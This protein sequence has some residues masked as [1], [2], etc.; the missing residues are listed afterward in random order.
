MKKNSHKKNIE[1]T[2]LECRL[3]FRVSVKEKQEI[4]HKA[5]LCAMSP[6][7]Y[8]RRCV[9]G[10]TPKL[11]LTEQETK[12]FISLA[13]ARAD[14]VHIKNALSGKSQEELLRYFRDANFMNYWILATD[15]I[16]RR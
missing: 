10:H 12:A 16:I 14:I 2:C 5:K 8:I 7:K 13:D 15:K 3:A 6:S 9:V 11:H 1:K 4:E